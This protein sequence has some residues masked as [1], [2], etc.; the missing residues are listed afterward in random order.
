MRRLTEFIFAYQAA[1]PDFV[2]LVMVENIDNATHLARS[3]RIQSLNLSIIE[4]MGEI[5]RRGVRE[6]V[7]RPGIDLI[8]LHITLSALCFFPVS[9]RATF[10]RIFARDIASP[11]ALAR[12]RGVTCETVLA[13][14]ANRP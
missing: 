8:D 11:E 13:Y 9:N 12:R 14:L 5:Y 1:N 7:F 6:G 4:V 2:R 10:S 3:E